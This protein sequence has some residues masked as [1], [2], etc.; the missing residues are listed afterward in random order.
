M[1]VHAVGRPRSTWAHKARRAS[2]HTKLHRTLSCQY[3]KAWF[4]F[5]RVREAMRRGNL[6][7]PPMGGEGQI[8]EADET[9][10][11][12]TDKLRPRAA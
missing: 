8:V 1:H 10:Y 11:G 6:D 2:P 9:Y 5:H 12:A 3:N 4:I 7:L